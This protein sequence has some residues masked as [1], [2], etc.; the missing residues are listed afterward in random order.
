MLFYLGTHL[1]TWMQRTDIPLFISHRLLHKRRSM[2]KALGRWSLDSGGFTELSMY[3]RWTVEPSEY[4]DAVYRYDAEIGNLDWVAPQDWMCEPWIVAKT[5]L[6]VR[7]HQRRTV[8]NYLDLTMR[9]PLLPFVPVLQGWQLDDYLAHMEMYAAAGV[10]LEQCR[11]VGLGSVCR[12]QATSEIEEIVSTLA[13]CGLRL[14]GFG[15]KSSGL[16]RYG[17]LLTS[18]DSMAWSFTGRRVRPCPVRPV[19][20]CANCWHFAQEWRSKVIGQS[21]AGQ[22][23]LDLR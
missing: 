8:D 11:V 23:R 21:M 9:A 10:K 7:E 22:A 15:V 20:S 2:P 17:A 1:V 12:R 14:H 3:G 5:G 4:I 18:A 16:R 6:S 19:G 13:G